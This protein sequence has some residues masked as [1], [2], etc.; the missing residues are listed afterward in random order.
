MEDECKEAKDL[1][2]RYI[3]TDNRLA[4]QKLLFLSQT[5][6]RFLLIEGL[7]LLSLCIEIDSCDQNGCLHNTDEKSVEF[8]L[9]EHGFTCPGLPLV[10][11]DGYKLIDNTVVLLECFVRSSEASFEQKYKEDYLKIVSLKSDLLQS[12]LTLIPLIDGRSSYATNLMPEW[13][14]QRIR[15]LLF[16]LLK[17]EQENEKLLEESEY[18]RLVESLNFK[19]GKLS[20]VDSINILK[21]FRSDHYR[22]IL[23]LCHS[24]INPLMSVDEVNRSII[25]VFHKFRSGLNSGELKPSFRQ[26]NLTEI[27]KEF[28]ELYEEVIPFTEDDR[29][30]IFEDAINSC[31]LMRMLFKVLPQPNSH[32][33][34]NETTT[35]SKTLLSVLNKLKSSKVLNTRRKLL[36]GFDV[37]ILIC[38][39][40]DR[41]KGKGGFKE[42]WVGCCFRSVNDRLVNIFSTQKDLEKLLVA[43][44]RSKGGSCVAV[45]DLF[46][47]YIESLTSKIIGGL[48]LINFDFVSSS[49]DWLIFKE[50]DY[51]EVM[52]FHENIPNSSCP[53]MVYDSK[54]LLT[55]RIQL[56]SNSLDLSKCLARLSS[57][58]LALVNSMKTSSTAKLRQNEFG[59]QRYKVVRCKECYSQAFKLESEEFHLLYLKTGEGSKCYSINNTLA[60]HV[61]SFYADPKRF[62]A[63]IFSGD[64]LVKMKEVMLSWLIPCDELKPHLADLNQLLGVLLLLILTNPTKRCQKLLQNMRYITMAAVS[65]YHHVRLMEKV[66]EDLITDAE[67]T[68]YRVLRKIWSIILD[69]EVKTLLTNRFKFLLNVSYL[70]HLITKETPDRL[71]DQIKCFEKFLKPKINNQYAFINP[72]EIASNE[73]LSQTLASMEKFTSKNSLDPRSVK[74]DSPGICKLI[75]SCMIS[76]LNNKSAL[77]HQE[78]NA[79]SSDPLVSAG[80][81]TA[82]DLASNKSVVVN[83]FQGDERLLNYDYNKL[84]AAV[85]CEMSESFIRKG[86]LFHSKEDY[87]YKVNKI[88]SKLVLGPTERLGKVDGDSMEPFLDEEQEAMLSNIKDSIDQVLLNYS[89]QQTVSTD[90][91]S[92]KGIH[93]LDLMIDNKVFKRLVITEVS[94]HF[95]ED[96]DQ[97]ILPES[98]YEEICN[99]AYNNSQLRGLY[100]L[101]DDEEL[102]PIEK[103]SQKVAKK[104][105]IEGDYFSCFK[106]LLLQMNANA[107]Q[108]KL[109]HYNRKLVNYRFDMERLMNDVRIS[110]RESNS[111]AMSKA[112]SLTNCLSSALKNL[113]FY[114]EESPTS[115]NSVCPD[116]GRLK[117]ALSYKEQVGGNRELYIGDLRTKMFTRLVEDYFEAL[118][119]GFKGSCLNSEEEF[120]NAVMMMKLNVRQAWLSYSM[121]HS[122]WGPMMCPFLFLL[123]LQNLRLSS[124]ADNQHTNSGKD[125]ISSMLCWHIHK[126]VEIPFPVVQAM[127]RSFL[128]RKLGLMENTS[129]SDVETFFF[130][131]LQSKVVPSHISSLLDMGQGIL[132]NVSDFYGLVTEKFINLCLKQIFQES[133]DSFTSSDDQITIFGHELSQMVE[134]QPEEVLL[135]IEFHNYLS[136]MLNKF[137]SPKSVVSRFV[138]EFKS[139]FFIW[140]EEVPLL[141]KFVAASLHN[142]KCK[143]PHQLCETIDTILDQSVANGVPVGLCNLIQERTLNLLRYSQYPIDPFLM[144][145]FSDVKDWVDGTRGYRMQRSVERCDPDGTT[146]I[147]KILRRIYDKLKRGQIHEEFTTSF[148]NKEPSDALRYLCRLIDLEMPA[149]DVGSLRWLNLTHYNPLRMVLRQ[150]VVYPSKLDWEPIKIPSIV[151]TIQN[152]LSSTFT[153]GAQKLLSEAINKSAFQS[154]IASGFIGLC[155]TIGSRCIRSDDK[156]THYIRTIMSILSNCRSVHQVECSGGIICWRVND[157][158]EESLELE[159]IKPMLRPLLWDYFCITL[160]NALEI[161]P[162]VLGDPFEKEGVLTEF[163]SCNY[164]PIK[165]TSHRLLEDKVGINHL[166][167][168]VRRLY[169]SI[170]EEHIMPFMSDLASLK[171]KW[172]PRIKF[173]DLC[174]TLDVMCE[175]VSLVSHIVK[176]KREEHYVVL[177]GELSCMH[178]RH[179]ATLQE[180]RVISSSD[181]IDNFVKQVYFDSFIRPF[182]ITS[183]TLGSMTWFPH[184]SALPMGESSERLGVLQ[185]FVMKVIHKGIERPMFRSDLHYGY[186]W[187]DCAEE[188]VRINVNA[189]IRAGLT[190][191]EVFEDIGEFFDYLAKVGE[192]H[193]QLTLTI[194]FKSSRQFGSLSQTFRI[195]LNLIGRMLD[196]GEFCPSNIQP[197]FSG[198]I[199]QRLIKECLPLLSNLDLFKNDDTPWPLLTGEI[200]DYIRGGT[201]KLGEFVDLRVSDKQSILDTLHPDDFVRVGP[202]WEPVPL[203]AC[204]GEVKEGQLVLGG[205]RPNLHTPDFLVLVEELVGEDATLLVSTLRGI[206]SERMKQGLTRVDI[207]SVLSST[208]NGLTILTQSLCDLGDWVEF[209]GYHL[210]YSRSLGR[211]MKT[212]PLGRQRLKGR[213]CVPVGESD[214]VEDID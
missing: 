74:Q 91:K 67:F 84:L 7:K 145:Q 135:L 205:L 158:N 193:T 25:E 87:D 79:L 70:C 174:V 137:V 112:L 4:R 168:S 134:T 156:G 169:P 202:D 63:P 89:S 58:C 117:F 187:V 17:F 159:W 96:F 149:V 201:V 35:T 23:R 197:L 5:E 62:F 81:A 204:N 179:S 163:D 209:Q 85:V 16:S 83:K 132:H 125:Y 172:T 57:I 2:V 155:K 206:F 66:K 33:K 40:Y 185:S 18:I 110:E 59:K 213:L 189:L 192:G 122:K 165:P 143:D 133:V 120:L 71:T 20:G 56:E 103:M 21:D 136:N 88:L 90:S 171:L 129:C 73:E 184:K 167:H 45:D 210:C 186:T 170:F 212:S 86:R 31:P 19:A 11:P 139:R 92:M 138:A 131:K 162:W 166:I 180:E 161:G 9:F 200:A 26:T 98:I 195:I 43:R 164:F 121:D 111:E 144:Y 178:Q 12:G 199:D 42:E 14:N 50:V 76:S 77:S 53:I 109:T 61:E 123:T 107:L 177:C 207:L 46:N 115:Y 80:C 94:H 28:N 160:S 39:C 127:T 142:V 147:R 34:S 8:I 95:V 118:T 29:R 1:V 114:S 78:R 124:D 214:Y 150:K 116:S 52:R 3:P 151:K 182:V 104:F 196:N 101:D 203:V 183:R 130:E 126:I 153:R 188:S 99:N 97:S 41:K 10:V 82:L 65:D 105:F 36:L 154:S 64:V 108:G 69:P 146:F 30:D 106:I 119:K 38:H 47:S 128:K 49:F 175:A 75:F 194:V 198:E 15:H 140:G 148:L 157:L 190:E 93:H 100:F 37:L 141:T 60:D 27:L 211:L 48:K 55:D 24:G 32:L 152:K 22:N 68:V 208:P 173:L 13:V 72:G 181:V 113:C 191:T 44:H 54:E 176:W 51:Y 6:P 102:C